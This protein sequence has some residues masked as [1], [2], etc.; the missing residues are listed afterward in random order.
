MAYATNTLNGIIQLNDRNLAEFEVSDLFDNS[1]LAEKLYAKK[2]TQG[3]VHKYLRQTVAAGAGFR[4]IGD[5]IAI[6]ASQDELVTDTL[7]LLDASFSVD[8]GLV[9]SYKNGADAFMT[10]E[11]ARH[12]RAAYYAIENQ[13]LNSTGADA[14]GFAGFATQ[15]TMDKSDDSMVI[16]ATGTE[17]GTVVYSAYLMRTGVDAVSLVVGNDGKLEVSDMFL[18]AIAGST[19]VYDCYRVSVLGYLGL[20]LGSTYDVARICNLSDESTKG[21]TDAKIAS[22][23]SLFPAN[24][25]PNLIVVPRIGL[26]HLQA[27][28][29]ATSASGTPAPFPTESFGVEIVVSDALST[30][31]SLLTT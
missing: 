3:T 18:A 22:A 1:S 11:T 12:L 4:T 6:A 17:G 28:R 8:K 26:A 20:Q 29:T 15:T 2:A 16:D 21:L 27:S 10:R 25:R 30:S 31:E 23:I 19:A 14:N 24:R 7:T 13:V 5:G 9:D